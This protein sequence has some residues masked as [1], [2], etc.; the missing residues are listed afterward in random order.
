MK[1]YKKFSLR[2]LV[3][4]WFCFPLFA[5]AAITIEI[6]RSD[7]NKYGLAPAKN[8]TD[9]EKTIRFNKADCLENIDLVFNIS[10][11][12]PIDGTLYLAV[13]SKCNDKS[14]SEKNCLFIDNVT[15]GGSFKRK[16][17]DL[18]EKKNIISTE[19]CTGSD[20]VSIWAGRTSAS[21]L[22]DRDSATE[23]WSSSYKLS[24]DM[25]P[26]SEPKKISSVP[27]SGKVV[28]KWQ[29]NSSEDTEASDSGL[30]SEVKRII[31]LHTDGS[32]NYESQ[33]TDDTEDSD[34]NEEDDAGDVQSPKIIFSGSSS[35]NG[36]LSTYGAV[37][38]SVSVTEDSTDENCPS[39]GFVA[40]GGHIPGVYGETI[41]TTPSS[42]E[43]A[44]TGLK[45]GK[46]YKFG[47]IA[48]DD[49]NNPSVISETVC[50]MPNVTTN[51]FDKYKE[52]GG[53]GGKFC[54]IATATYGSYDHFVVRILRNF[55][56]DFLAQIPNG[57]IIIDTY[58][59]VGPSL[60]SIVND[61]QL[62]KT[63]MKI[64]LFTFALFTMPL[65]ALGP[66]GSIAFGAALLG[67]VL[68]IRRRKQKA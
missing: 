68:V 50:R 15:P 57:Q 28:I 65:S 45:N 52:A 13:G 14:T 58:Y 8:K 43:L 3:I 25:T 20:N 38:D 2:V 19:N 35:N 49:Y 66:I 16:L 21:D 34:T 37:D 41:Q 39:N 27:G 44:V 30:D 67:F 24:W 46:M 42:G 64:G 33:G 53:K 48:L 47:V 63:T 56:D 29:V 40:G 9:T 60:A 11:T 1:T 12:S 22:N 36:L 26:P 55:R 59:Q 10:E 23:E 6:N 5:N 4:S 62:L 18:L 54:F 51:A 7:S 61:N 32:I 31:V 17:R